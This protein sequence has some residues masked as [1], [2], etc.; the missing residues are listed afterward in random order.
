MPAYV[1]L[2]TTHS[3][4]P[5]PGLP[6]RGLPRGRATTRLSPT[7]TR[8]PTA[9]RFPTW[10]CRP[11]VDADAAQGRRGLLGAFDGARRDVDASGLMEAS[12]ASTARHSRSSR[13]PRPARVRPQPGRS[14][15]PRPLRPAP[16]VPERL[17]ARRLVEAGVRFVTLT[18]SGWDFHS[19]LESGMKRVFPC[20]TRPSAPWS[21]TWTAAECSTRPS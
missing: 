7:A 8:I 12:T 14:P 1:G 2:P 6:R 17:L 5:G 19:S 11:G 16:V 13:A 21:K 10:R 9:T 4:G 20:S 18:F 15:A 3:V